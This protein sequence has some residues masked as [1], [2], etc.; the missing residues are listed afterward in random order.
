MATAWELLTTRSTVTNT[1]ARV[2]FLNPKKTDGGPTYS[3][4]TVQGVGTW[5]TEL[6]ALQ[7]EGGVAHL[8]TQQAV[9]TL[10][11]SDALHTLEVDADD[12]INNFTA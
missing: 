3:G 2:H 1:T 4:A 10:D 6:S 5:G 11:A 8:S 12:A 7:T 9:T